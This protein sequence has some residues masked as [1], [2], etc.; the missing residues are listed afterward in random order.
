MHIFHALCDA[1]L[2]LINAAAA[3]GNAVK[4]QQDVLV[5]QL[6]A[7]YVCACWNVSITADE[8]LESLP[9]R[10]NGVMSDLHGGSCGK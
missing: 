2:P 5:K 9:T 8:S 7:L 4:Q 3:G 6:L 1:V 10:N